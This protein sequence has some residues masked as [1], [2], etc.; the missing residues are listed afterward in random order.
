M[1]NPRDDALTGQDARADKL[2]VSELSDD[3]VEAA[4]DRIVASIDEEQGTGNT[5]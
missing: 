1:E 4:F 3:E 5:A 2:P